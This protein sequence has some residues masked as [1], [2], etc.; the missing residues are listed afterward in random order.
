MST[1]PG[2]HPP[3]PRPETTD[4]IRTIG[5]SFQGTAENVNTGS[6]SQVNYNVSVAEMTD[7]QLRELL[8]TPRGRRR[9]SQDG[10]LTA[11]DVAWHTARFVVPRGFPEPVFA[12]ASEVTTQYITGPS[13]SGRW[14]ASLCWLERSGGPGKGVRQLRETETETEPEPETEQQDRFFT[15][16]PGRGELLLLDLRALDS[17]RLAQLSAELAGFESEVRVAG[18]RLAVII[19]SEQQPKLGPAAS[20]RTA[21]LHPPGATA[22]LRAHL[23]QGNLT[24]DEDVLAAGTSQQLLERATAGQAAELAQLTLQVHTARHG[25]GNFTEWFEEARG[26][27]Q[28][29][30]EDLHELLQQHSST[31]ERTVLL[32]AAVCEGMPLEQVHQAAQK[33]TAHVPAPAEEEPPLERTGLTTLLRRL[34]VSVYPSRRVSFPKI[35]FDAAVRHRFWDDH[36]KLHAEFV[37]WLSG[38]VRDSDWSQQDRSTVADR[39]AEVCLRGDR[40]DVVLELIQDWTSD[41]RASELEATRLLAAAL[42]D[43]RAAWETRR[44]MRLWARNP[45]LPAARVRV[46]TVACQRI[47]RHTHP[48]QA[49]VRLLLLARNNNP[50][51]AAVAER[52]LVDLVQQPYLRWLAL[53]QLTRRV[54]PRAR[55]WELFTRITALE[56]LSAADGPFPAS[57]LERE[58]FLTCAKRAMRTDREAARLHTRRW[59]AASATD[60]RWRHMLDLIVRAGHSSG[61]TDILYTTARRWVLETPDA[62]TRAERREPAMAL[63]THLRCSRSRPNGSGD[64]ASANHIH[65]TGQESLR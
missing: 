40:L 54:E 39:L 61:C 28:D 16:G 53:R 11:Q 22:V 17:E 26:S 62:Q 65:S 51:S 12:T 3:P 57:Q 36:Q 42:A 63:L 10:T 50:N 30:N 18:A 45:D 37:A 56:V 47:L 4:S 15:E 49:I 59:L 21:R 60:Y 44:Q 14:A 52:A 43:P 2:T 46:V 8:K 7:E 9:R 25:R 29:W 32:A 38:L 58:V 1:H 20:A 13:G 35:N 24:V 6:G 34:G 31:V 19:D 55:D 5:T 64:F 27:A 33:L 48:D 23:Q 41:S